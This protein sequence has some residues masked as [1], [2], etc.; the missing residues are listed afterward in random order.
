MR[1][2][3]NVIVIKP[4]LVIDDIFAVKS[5]G[6]I[7]GLIFYLFFFLGLKDSSGLS[8]PVNF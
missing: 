8:D 2:S 6:M 4:L 1:G 7:T 5:R 3:E